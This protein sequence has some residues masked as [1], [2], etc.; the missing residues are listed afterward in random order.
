MSKVVTSLPKGMMKNSII[1]A[2]LALGSYIS[3][4]FLT[5]LLVHNEMIGEEMIYSLVCVSAGLS[6]FVGCGYSVLRGGSGGVLSASAVVMVFLTLTVAVALLT[7]G[8][9]VVDG[10]L[11]GVGIAMAAGGL[12]A[13]LV[14]GLAAN[15]NGIGRRKQK[16][17]RTRK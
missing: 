1:G 8:A 3:L 16:T 6:S 5:A 9:D 14:A 12:L 11:T 10:G 7:G 2:I 4:Q 17:R 15:K 13:A